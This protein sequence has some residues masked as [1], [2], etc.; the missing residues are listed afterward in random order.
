VAKSPVSFDHM[1]FPKGA[2]MAVILPVY[3]AAKQIAQ[4]VEEVRDFASV[5]PEYSFIFVDDGSTDDTRTVIANAIKGIANV[6][7]TGYEV[8]RGKGYA[9]RFGFGSIDA[10][11]YCFTDSDL[12]Y[13]LELLDTIRAELSCYDVVIGSRKLLQ[14]PRRPNLLRH[15]LGEGYN[16]LMRLTLGLPYRDTQAGLKGFNRE[17]IERIL[18]KLTICGFGFDAE[19][20]YI[21]SKEGYSIQEIAVQERETH[22]YKTGKI[23][24]SKD[25]LR[26]FRDLLRVRANDLMGRYG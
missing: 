24:L 23:K 21:A 25:S 19:L 2:E 12:A 7:L 5:R 9:V 10:R 6:S 4:V 17:V 3:N 1:S 18:P 15:L 14:R 16:Y 20:L 13:P 8:N 26:M 22:N 11:S